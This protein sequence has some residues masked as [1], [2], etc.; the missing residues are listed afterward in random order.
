VVV[1]DG[2]LRKHYYA[3]P[4]RPRHHFVGSV[5]ESAGYY[6]HRAMYACPT[7]RLHSESRSRIDGVRDARRLIDIFGFRDVV[8]H[9]RRH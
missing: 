5:S 7:T 4:W 8:K 1:G 6:A 9:E 3:P 2:P